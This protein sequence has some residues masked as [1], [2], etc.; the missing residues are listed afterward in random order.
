MYRTGHP[1]RLHR[2]RESFLSAGIRPRLAIPVIH[3]LL[4]RL[5]SREAAAALRHMEFSTREID[6]IGELIP[7]TEKALKMLKGSKTNAPRDASTRR[8]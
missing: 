2:A 6:A 3:F 1:R 7:E 5:K 4:G 8:C